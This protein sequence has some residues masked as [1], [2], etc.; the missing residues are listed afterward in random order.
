MK[1]ELKHKIGISEALFKVAIDRYK[2]DFVV[3]LVSGG[4]DSMAMYNTA[5]MVGYIDK[6]LHVDTT[7]GIKDVTSFVG[8]N[9]S[10]DF[11]VV[12]TNEETYEEIVLKNGFPGPGQ[13]G[14]MYIR[15]KERALRVF[16]RQLQNK[17]AFCR[18]DGGTAHKKK[19]PLIYHPSYPNSEALVIKKPPRKIM[20]LTGARKDESV[21]RMGHVEEFKKEGNQIWVNLIAHHSKQDCYDFQQT[22][23]YER[24]PGSKKCGRSQECCCGSYGSEEEL[25]ELE[26]FFPHDPTTLMLRRLQNKLTAEKHKYAHYGH[27]GNNRKLTT[28]EVSNVKQ[29]LCSTCINNHSFKQ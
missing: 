3:A 11:N 12:R 13:H 22:M 27:G 18:I 14:T 2:P 19:T 26:F 21:R 16:Q 10:H 20:Y 6:V 24:G 23:K 29:R 8:D 17:D 25:L 5:K 9:V 1:K 7:V 4:D 28:E 15:L